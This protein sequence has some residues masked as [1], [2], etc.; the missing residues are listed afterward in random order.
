MFSGIYFSQFP[1]VSLPF[2]ELLLCRVLPGKVEE[3]S[4]DENGSLRDTEIGDGFNSRKVINDDWDGPPGHSVIHIVKDPA[5]ILPY[6]VIH[7]DDGDDDDDGDSSGSSSQVQQAVL[8]STSTVTTSRKR[9]RS[10]S[11]ILSVFGSLL[12]LVLNEDC[13]VCQSQ[14]VINVPQL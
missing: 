2:G 6:C 11:G 12:H 13:V 3:C 9:T 10:S 7:L 5:Q 14:L 4:R 8:P 1:A